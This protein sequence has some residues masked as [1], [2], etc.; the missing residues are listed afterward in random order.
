M[1]VAGSR[2]GKR[3]TRLRTSGPHRGPRDPHREHTD[4]NMTV[5]GRSARRGDG[6]GGAGARRRAPPARVWLTAARCGV[7]AWRHHHRESVDRRP[8]GAQP[9]N[10]AGGNTTR[11]E[12]AHGG[13]PPANIILVRRIVGARGQAGL[14]KIFVLFVCMQESI[15]PLLPPPVRITHTTAIRLRDC[16]AIHILPPTLPPYPYAI[17]HTILA[18]TISCIGQR[19]SGR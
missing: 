14:Y 5:A 8:E 1:Y 18:M 16:C 3:A 9:P 17:H 13:T 7:S 12:T 10:T 6:Q 11:G 2:D 15:I 4:H 19:L